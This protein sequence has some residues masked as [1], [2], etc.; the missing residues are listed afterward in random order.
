MSVVAI[1]LS[2]LGLTFKVALVLLL[3]ALAVYDCQKQARYRIRFV[4]G[5][6]FFNDRQVSLSGST[7]V[8]SHL[9]FLHFFDDKSRKKHRL[10]LWHLFNPQDFWYDLQRA[11]VLTDKGAISQK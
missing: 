7:V 4:A 1:G 3:V 8:Y 2:G 6:W 5:R 11:I 9:I 10:T